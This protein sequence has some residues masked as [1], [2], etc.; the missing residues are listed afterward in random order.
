MIYITK[1]YLTDK[2]EK[3]ENQMN[4]FFDFLTP[5]G[6]IGCHG[7]IDAYF[8]KLFFTKMEPNKS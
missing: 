1:Q 2:K 7:N 6:K 4:I 3:N 5:P 8:A